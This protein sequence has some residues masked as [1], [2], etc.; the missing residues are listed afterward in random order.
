METR[1]VIEVRIFVLVLNS[2]YD[3]YEGGQIVAFSDDYNRLVNW[4]MNQLTNEPYRLE[5]ENNRY[6]RRFKNDSPLRNYNPPNSLALNETDRFNHGI[7]DEWIYID[8]FENVKSR[9]TFV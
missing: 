8:N 7:H 5:E 1:E 4:Y 2:I 6:L 3:C 9:F